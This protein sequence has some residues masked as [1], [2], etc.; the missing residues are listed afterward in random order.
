[1]SAIVNA[2]PLIALALVDQLDLL[3]QIFG[4]IIVPLTVY[5]EVIGQGL[6]RPGAQAISQAQ[7]LQ[8]MAPTAVSTVEPLLLGLD[9]GEL[10]VLL[11]AQEQAPDWVIIDERQARR[12]AR[13]MGLPVK[14]TVGVLLAVGLSGLRSEEELLDDLEKMI[15]HGIRVSPQLQS[16]LKQELEKAG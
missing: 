10:D 6:E 1:M 8:V 15:R 4:D 2:T 3:P 13:A 12:A 11:L 14:G 16:W 7:W 5:N 9:R